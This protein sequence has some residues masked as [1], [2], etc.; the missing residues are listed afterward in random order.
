ML[1]LLVFIALPWQL[2]E[3]VGANSGQES[4]DLGGDEM[5]FGWCV[6]VLTLLIVGLPMIDFGEIRFVSLFSGSD[7]KTLSNLMMGNPSE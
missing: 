1:P 5:A 4:S 2:T 6:T 3:E 7:R